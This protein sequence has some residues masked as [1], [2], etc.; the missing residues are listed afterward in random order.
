MTHAF[1]VEPDESVLMHMRSDND[2]DIFS[3][4]SAQAADAPARAVRTKS[5]RMFKNVVR[6]ANLSITLR[7]ALA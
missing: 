7:A 6:P 1:P 3:L 4:H 2:V 5:A